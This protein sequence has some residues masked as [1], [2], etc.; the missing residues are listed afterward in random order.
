MNSICILTFDDYINANIVLQNLQ[1]NGINAWLQDENFSTMFPI[2]NIANGGIKLYVQEDEYL[3][4]LEI[5]KETNKSTQNKTLC[6]NCQSTN[7]QLVNKPNSFKNLF[8][9][10]LSFSLASYALKGKQCFYCYECKKYFN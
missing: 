7:V 9:A 6:P 5:L 2:Y 8:I 10:L 4:T 1:S 3:Q